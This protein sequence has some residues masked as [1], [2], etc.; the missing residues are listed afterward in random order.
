MVARVSVASGD[1]PEV[2]AL[3]AGTPEADC[4]TGGPAAVLVVEGVAAVGAPELAD[5][6]DEADDDELV[7]RDEGGGA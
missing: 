6:V 2:I 4:V 3:N 5:R 7:E 1:A